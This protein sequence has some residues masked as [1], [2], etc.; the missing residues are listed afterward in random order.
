MKILGT[1]FAFISLLCVAAPAYAAK[2]GEDS[3]KGTIGIVCIGPEGGYHFWNS[4]IKD[5]YESCVDQV[6]NAWIAEDS[7]KKPG[8]D[9]LIGGIDHYRQTVARLKAQP[10]EKK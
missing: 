7:G 6:V 4:E 3:G 9:D 8:F 1:T 10:K 5:E 2:A